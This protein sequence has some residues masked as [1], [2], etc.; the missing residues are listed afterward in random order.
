MKYNTIPSHAEHKLTLSIKKLFTGNFNSWN[1]LI[2]QIDGK[3]IICISSYV[4]VVTRGINEEKKEQEHF[5]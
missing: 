4:T 1:F 2:H 3:K 5:L